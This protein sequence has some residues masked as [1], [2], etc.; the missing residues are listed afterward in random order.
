MSRCAF[1]HSL[2]RSCE[3][4]R[5][6]TNKG[7]WSVVIDPCSFVTHLQFRMARASYCGAVQPQRGKG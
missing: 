6:V 1:V 2:K 7:I 4:I 5:L 3:G